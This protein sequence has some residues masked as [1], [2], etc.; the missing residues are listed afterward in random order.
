MKSRIKKFLILLTLLFFTSCN[1]YKNTIYKIYIITNDYKNDTTAYIQKVEPVNINDSSVCAVNMPDFPK[2]EKI[3]EN[4]K[5]YII[6]NSVK[7]DL[8][9]GRVD[10]IGKK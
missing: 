9:G 6:K 2:A 1:I 5:I 4:G 8:L 7:Y 10:S 3:V